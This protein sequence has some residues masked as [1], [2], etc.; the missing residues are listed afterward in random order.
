MMWNSLVMAMIIAVG[1]IVISLLS[2]F[3][4]IYFRFPFRSFF[5][6]MIFITLMLPVEVRI[7]PT[8]EV[9]AD[10]GMFDT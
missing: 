4:I 5:F 2:A 8:V 6:W 10:L 9:V 3:A 7:V 1:K